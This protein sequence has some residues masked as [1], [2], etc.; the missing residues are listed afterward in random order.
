M[1]YYNFDYKFD[2]DYDGFYYNYDMQSLISPSF[3]DHKYFG[4]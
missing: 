4:L 3:I 2:Q 1:F